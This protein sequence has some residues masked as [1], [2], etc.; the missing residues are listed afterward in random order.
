MGRP[1]NVGKGAID[2]SLP[3]KH[4][5]AVNIGVG[6]VWIEQDRFVEIG[7]REVEIAFPVGGYAAFVV[8]LGIAGRSFSGLEL[9]RLRLVRA[10][11]AGPGIGR[12]GFARDR[13]SPILASPALKL[14]DRPAG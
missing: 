3:I 4:D 1:G 2:F 14:S 9:V 5:A 10:D 12:L 11:F 7:K 8:E 13:A 6:K